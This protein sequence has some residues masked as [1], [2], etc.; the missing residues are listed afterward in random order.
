MIQLPPRFEVQAYSQHIL[1]RLPHMY[2]RNFDLAL[3]SQFGF[4]L[5]MGKFALCDAIELHNGFR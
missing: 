1:L 3:P 5:R 2:R 4:W